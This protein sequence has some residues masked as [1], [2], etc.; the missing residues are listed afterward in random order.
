M[1]H[2]VRISHSWGGRVAFS[3]DR[4]PHHGV[5]DGMHYAMGYCGAGLPKGT[6]LGHKTALQI[7]GQEDAETP[8]TD[9]RFATLPFYNGW[10]WFIP[11]IS[12]YYKLRDRLDR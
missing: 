10:P 12:V 1:L 11:A 9:T 5:H 6:Y 4:L 7:L 3:F 2:G 8:F